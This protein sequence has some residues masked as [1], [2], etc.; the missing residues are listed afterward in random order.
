[1]SAHPE[2]EVPSESVRTP[3]Y[4]AVVGSPEPPDRCLVCSKAMRPRKGKAVCSPACR[5]ERSRRREVEQRQ[6]RHREF[7]EELHELATRCLS[8]AERLNTP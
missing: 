5:R 7:R 3:L 6:L 1:M 8:L 2:P 4:R